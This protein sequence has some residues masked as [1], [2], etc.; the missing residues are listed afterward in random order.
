M[1]IDEGLTLSEQQK[2]SAFFSLNPHLEENGYLKIIIN[3]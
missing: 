2:K 1:T 3:K